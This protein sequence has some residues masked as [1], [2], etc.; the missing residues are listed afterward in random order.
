MS[1]VNN[2]PDV[3]RLLAA[4]AEKIR[5]VRYCWLVT[6][7]ADGGG[8]PRPMGRLPRDAGDDEWTLRFITD[9]R[10][11]KAADMRRTSRVAI[12]LQHD[13]DQAFITLFGKALL[14]EQEAE[15]RAR[16]NDAYGAF[17]PTAEDRASAVF[18]AVDVERM[19]LW[20]RGVTPE[21]FGIRTTRL[22]RDPR[23]GWQVTL[24]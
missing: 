14:I 22:E 20:I 12:I 11:R 21:P 16:W 13:P 5:K 17:F 3:S 4:A 24:R 10:S 6:A 2:A 19:E 7:A 18:A 9:G 8:N 23:R 15:V 1:L